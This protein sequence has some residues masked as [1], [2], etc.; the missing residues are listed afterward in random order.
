MKRFLSQSSAAL[1]ITTVS[2]ALLLAVANRLIP[3]AAQTRAAAPVQRF[4][5]PQQAALA[6]QLAS[7]RAD[8]LQPALASLVELDE[9]GVY[10]VW[11]A[12]LKNPDPALRRQAWRAYRAHAPDL[13]RKQFIPQIARFNR[14]SAEFLSLA[15]QTDMQAVIWAERSGE[16]VAAVPFYLLEQLRHEGVRV[17]VLYDSV[18]DWQAA[19]KRGD[20]QAQAITPAYLSALAEPQT[21]VRIAVIDLTSRA[22]PARGY[23][24]WLG[25]HEN[26]LLRTESRL[27]YL[28][29]V[30]ASDSTAALDARL[31]ERFTRRG[32]RVE[33][34]YTAAEF[35]AVAPQLFGQSFAAGLPTLKTPSLQAATVEGKFHSYEETLNEFTQLA[36]QYPERAKFITLGQSYEGRQIFALKIGS[37]PETDDPTKPDVLITGCHHAREWISVEPP[38]Y[39]ANQLITRYAEDDA[40]R[41][42]VDH[43]QIW[44]VPILNPD[45]LTYSQG[46]PNDS[47]NA[48]RLWRKN[49]RPA[50]AEACATSIGTDLNR[51]YDFQWRLE[52]DEPCPRYVDDVG[53]SDDPREEVYRG[54]Q[55]ESEPE[56]KAIKTLL[57]D[58]NRRFRAQLDYHN[59]S[60][61]ILYP[62][63][64]HALA[65]PDAE[66]LTALA[67]GMSVEID[68]A[69]HRTYEPRQAFNLYS[70]TGS[71]VDYAYGANQVAAPFIVEMRPQ[72]GNFAVFESQIAPINNENWA[73]AK[74]LMSWATGPPIVEAVEAYQATSDGVFSKL[75]YSAHWSELQA[76]GTRQLIVDNR[77]LGLESRRLQLRLRF[78]KT[79]DLTTPMRVTLGRGDNL[80]ELSLMPI[81]G[82][83]GWRKTIYQDDTWIGEATIPALD[84]NLSAWQFSIAAHD[85]A[86]L[87]LDGK[88]QTLATYGVGTN[89]WRDYEDAGGEGNTG[90]ADT[91][92]ILSPTLRDERP[93]I[94]VG[95][96]RGDERFAGGDSVSVAW[97]VFGRSIFSPAEQEV[98]LSTDGGS[99]FSRLVGAIAATA[100]RV[101][102]TLPRAATT[103][104]TFI[105]SA[106]DQAGNTL[107]STNANLFTIGANVTSG[108]SILFT[109]S[110]LLNE[111]WSDEL[112]DGSAGSSGTTRLILN[113]TVTNRSNV[114]I[115]NPFLRVSEVNRDH[116]LLSRDAKSKSIIGALQSTNAGGDNL[117]APNETVA[118]RLVIGL[119]S[120]KKFSYFIELYGVPVDGTI[121]AGSAIRLWKGKPKTK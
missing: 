65:P 37:A 105:V 12:A 84:D 10:E 62:W 115:A 104:A 107:A 70:T 1:W 99:D 72:V 35:A 69:E 16:T 63:G 14:S 106:R 46:A 101:T 24:D 74:W 76:D 50:A 3:A 94:L 66:T 53:G 38:V 30:G 59:F 83:F 117:L 71:S 113:L 88:P 33:G 19:A 75:V 15:G 80:E 95:T 41:Y 58:P 22:R 2:C 64:Y 79:M 118:M 98:W 7:G 81:E 120:T 116:V 90:G 39:F 89:Q 73:G 108:I 121:N 47:L 20:A 96:P 34:Y 11:Q 57:A 82:N 17:E 21:Q 61:L 29:V 86:A 93:S 56:I 110:E 42:L 51:N 26:I 45:G 91:N 67:A 77:V 60:Q 55:P 9:A 97:T 103:K 48:V 18:A 100:D 6:A 54:D 40:A 111:S 49:R 52:G 112:A 13:I 44:I 23:S 92:H 114:T 32:Y 5:T 68:K 27:A 109:S 31:E 119:V 78:S 4:R 87:S 102:V 43:L 8:Q 36:Q 28:D 85:R 25:D